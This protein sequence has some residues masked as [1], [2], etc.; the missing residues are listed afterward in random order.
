MRIAAMT[1]GSSVF[2]AAARSRACRSAP[3]S[4]GVNNRSRREVFGSTTFSIDPYQIGLGNDEAIEAGAFWF[5]RKL[6]FRSTNPKIEQLARREEERIATD[7]HHRTSARTLKTL[8]QSPMVYGSPEWDRFHIRNIALKGAVD[9]I[10]NEIRR[11]KKG[12]TEAEYLRLLATDKK[13]RRAL[14]KLGS[15]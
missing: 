2:S 9:L 11:A 12:Q 6:G 3:I 10:P 8:A 1:C 7:P 5:Y 4:P 13:V 14:I 15:R